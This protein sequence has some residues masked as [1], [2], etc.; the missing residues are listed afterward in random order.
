MSA[1]TLTTP[2]A[3]APGLDC[4]KPPDG[5][6]PSYARIAVAQIGAGPASAWQAERDAVAAAVP[7][8]RQEFLQGRACAH[9]ALWALGLDG[10][11]IGVG[12]RR[13]PL[14]PD[15][16][17]GAISHGGGL[18][19]AAVAR[20]SDAWGLGLD[21]ELRE[22]PL[23]RELVELLLTPTERARLRAAGGAGREL[24]KLLF[25]AKESVYKC[26]SPRTGWALEHQ[27]VEIVLDLPR[28]AYRAVIAERFDG[29]EL[30]TAPLVGS[31]RLFAGHVVTALAA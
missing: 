28:R 11:P 27:D 15:G 5:L 23:D 29:R 16:V 25:S 12:D 1:I 10:G 14:W 13:Q 30:P 22:P 24:A 4:G 2:V 8:R 9:A 18:A 17:V 6:L 20:A 31:F 7:A 19:A 21:L 26:V 3:G